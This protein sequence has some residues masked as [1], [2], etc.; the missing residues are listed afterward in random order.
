MQNYFSFFI[1]KGYIES[2]SLSLTFYHNLLT[3][4]IFI[5]FITNSLSEI[6]YEKYMIN[7]HRRILSTIQQ[8]SWKSNA[9]KS[10]VS[11]VT[12]HSNRITIARLK[13]S[14][15]ADQLWY[16]NNI[17]FRTVNTVQIKDLTKPIQTLSL[18]WNLNLTQVYY[19]RH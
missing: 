12:K 17:L 10:N 4:T 6:W 18:S 14:K 15:N 11:N 1:I 2:I 13:K 8:Y 5:A 9:Y 16:W 3:W 19:V 7:K